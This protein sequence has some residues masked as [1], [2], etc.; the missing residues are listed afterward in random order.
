MLN[1]L[2]DLLTEQ[3]PSIQAVIR[4]NSSFTMKLCYRRMAMLI[5]LGLLQLAWYRVMLRQ[6]TQYLRPLTGTW[7]Q[8]REHTKTWKPLPVYHL[9]EETKGSKNLQQ[10]LQLMTMTMPTL[11]LR[12]SATTITPICTG[13]LKWKKKRTKWRGNGFSRN[14][15]SS[16]NYRF[17]LL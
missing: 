1:R 8:A 9:R 4:R 5:S 13:H 7:I 6:L 11:L 16:S 17:R 2:L 3:S 12:T 10:T 14:K 15:S